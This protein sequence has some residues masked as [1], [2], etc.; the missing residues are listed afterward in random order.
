MIHVL[1][2]NITALCF[3]SGVNFFSPYVHIYNHSIISLY[4]LCNSTTFKLSYFTLYRFGGC[5][6]D[7]LS[8]I[9]ITHG[10]C[11]FWYCC[12]YRNRLCSFFYSY[13][14]CI[15]HWMWLYT[16]HLDF[17]GCDWLHLMLNIL[18]GW[19]MRWSCCN[20]WQADQKKKQKKSGSW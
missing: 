5:C 15:G 13:L 7:I 6:C 11:M 19:Y 1:Y 20:W 8:D 16:D 2:I 14:V 4:S 9:W 17:M 10:N 12:I 18:D 3:Y